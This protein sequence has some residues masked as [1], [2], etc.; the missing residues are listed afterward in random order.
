LKYIEWRKQMQTL[1]NLSKSLARVSL[2]VLVLVG[3]YLGTKALLPSYPT[4]IIAETFQ[5]EQTSEVEQEETVEETKPQAKAKTQVKAPRQTLK[6]IT[7]TKKN[8]VVFNDVVTSLSVSKAQ[9]QLLTLDATLPKGEPIYLV[10][11]TP[12]GSV[13]AGNMFTDFVKGLNRPVHTVTLFSASMGF[14]FVQ[15]LGT[16]YITRSGKL[17][18]HRV[19]IGGL[20]G[21]IPGEAISRLNMI[22]EESNEMDEVVA[23]RLGMDLNEYRNLIYDE[24]WGGPSKSKKYN[25][26]DEVADVTC[27]SDLTGTRKE[28]V[29][30]FF[31][32]LDLVWSECPLITVPIEIDFS[33]IFAL[34]NKEDKSEKM[35]QERMMLKDFINKR[36]FDKENFVIDYIITG[37]YS[38]II[39]E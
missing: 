30:T 12:G 6:K 13:F 18:S 9:Y 20:R 21:Q 15:S 11:D 33:R 24:F 37:K 5:K 31:G 36:F 26:I 10:L 8:S 34:Q 28:T 29:F 22:I 4:D 25:M 23:L 27:G 3:S 19:S 35:V 2:V 39:S 17:M 7:L 1:K 38:E 32:P 14:H 16:R